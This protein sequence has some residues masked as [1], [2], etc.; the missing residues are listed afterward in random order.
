MRLRLPV[1]LREVM[2]PMRLSK[3]VLAIGVIVGQSVLPLPAARAAG[4]EEKAAICGAC[5]GTE[6]RPADPSIP[7]LWGQ[8]EGYIYL[9]LRDF[10]LGNRNSPLM[11]PVAGTLEKQD[12]KDLAA[13][14]ATKPWPKLEQPPAPADV[15]QHAEAVAD[16]GRLQ[17]LSSVGLAGRQRHAANSAARA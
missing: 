15:A 6:G 10:K 14:F 5:H 8:N 16:F 12:M 13:Y 4:V 1:V 2:F 9:Q 11:G 17:G 7:V 3:G